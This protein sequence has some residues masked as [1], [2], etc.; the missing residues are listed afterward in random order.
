MTTSPS[1]DHDK[2]GASHLRQELHETV[3]RLS[4]HQGVEAV[5][6]LNPTGDIVTQ[7]GP[8]ATPETA[9]LLENLHAAATAYIQ[10]TVEEDTDEMSFLQVRSK[11]GRELYVSPH[12]GFVLA[13]LKRS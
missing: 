11:G 4:S 5:Q 1:P 6:I 13:V 10:A 8:K 9:K 12:Q 2:N 7:T 3:S